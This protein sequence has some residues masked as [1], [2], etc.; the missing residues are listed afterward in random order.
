[1]KEEGIRVNNFMA[2]YVIGPL[3]VLNPPFAKYLLEKCGA[4]S[5]DLAFEEAAMEAYDAR[6]RGDIPILR[7]VFIIDSARLL[8]CMEQSFV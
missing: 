2:T 5:G 4:D 6:V 8:L 3:L 7:L 1:M